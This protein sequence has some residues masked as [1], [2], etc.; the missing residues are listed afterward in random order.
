MKRSNGWTEMKTKNIF[1]I[2][3]STFGYDTFRPLQE[4]C[5][6]SVL[7]KKDTLLI[8]LMGILKTGR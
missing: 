4:K 8:M 7:D 1:K 2:L 5:I 3:K 6:L